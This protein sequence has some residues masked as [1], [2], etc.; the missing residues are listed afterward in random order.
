MRIFSFLLITISIA[1]FAQDRST[2][3][4]TPQAFDALN[5]KQMSSNVL[6]YTDKEIPYA[7]WNQQSPQE[8]QA[9][10]LYPGFTEPTVTSLKNG[11]RKQVVEKMMVYVVRTKMVLNRPA[12]QINLQNLLQLDS[13][14]KFDP[15]IQHIQ[16]QQNQ[17]LGNVAGKGQISNFLWCSKDS[18]VRPQREIDLSYTNPK[19]R[20]WCADTA[21][22]ICVESCFL[23]NKGYNAAITLANLGRDDSEKKDFGIGFQ[24]ELRTFV[25]EEES[26]S[27]VPL[28][29]L[30]GLNTPVRGGFEQNSFYF[31]QLFQYAKILAVL[32]DHPTDP[33]KTIATIYVIIGVKKRTWDLPMVP[34]ILEGKSDK[35]NTSTGLTAGI[36]VFTQNIIKSIATIL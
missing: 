11:I 7:D 18:I 12:A 14:R 31:N 4:L 35:F 15:E 1:A 8:A 3:V 6:Y 20:E 26:G 28:H 2:Q 22:S 25:K 19:S 5:A 10:N 24:S 34:T 9:L 23:F 13:I 17:F 16:I 32:Q 29:A 30:T 21:H 27:P 36:P 33:N